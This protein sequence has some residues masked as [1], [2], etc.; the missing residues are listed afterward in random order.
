MS[1][2]KITVSE[3]VKFTCMCGKLTCICGYKMDKPHTMDDHVA[4]PA[5]GRRIKTDGAVKVSTAK[6]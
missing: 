2:P 3:I 4:C 6:R 5:C 1:N